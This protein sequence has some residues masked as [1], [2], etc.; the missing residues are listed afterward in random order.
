MNLCIFEFQNHF[1]SYFYIFYI[2]ASKPGR[3]SPTVL[4]SSC[5]VDR[6]L[7]N[8]AG[9][10]V[11]K[12]DWRTPTSTLML[13]CEWLSI[14]QMIAYHSLLL[15][16]KTKQTRKPGYIFSKINHKFNQRTRL[17]TMGGI[18]DI[19]RFETTLAQA[20]FLPR[21]IK[22]WNEKLPGNIRS[23]ECLNNF[24]EKIKTWIKQDIKI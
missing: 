9:R 5:M 24:K 21:T 18:R 13:Q 16:F 10:L 7:Q 6:V 3:W 20:S 8:K 12:L 17:A 19:R 4:W 22:M 14:R 1:A 15:L 2:L 23:E 11:T